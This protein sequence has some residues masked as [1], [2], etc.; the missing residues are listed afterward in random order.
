MLD[1]SATIQAYLAATAA[2]Q[3]TPGGGSVAALTGALAVALAECCISGDEMVGADIDLTAFGPGPADELLFNESQ[4]RIVLS[5]RRENAAAAFSMRMVGET[6][7]K[8]KRLGR[9]LAP[10]L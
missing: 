1:Q 7:R 3:P 2:R 10:C 8:N 4:S 5:V 9:R 6:Q